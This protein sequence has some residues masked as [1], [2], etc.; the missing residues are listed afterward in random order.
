MEP[1]EPIDRIEPA[2]PIDRIGT[3]G[4]DRQDR[5]ADPIDASEATLQ[6]ERIDQAD[7]NEPLD[8]NDVPAGRFRRMFRP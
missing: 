8:R 6:S 2:E 1:A 4:T 7:R 3:G 5:A